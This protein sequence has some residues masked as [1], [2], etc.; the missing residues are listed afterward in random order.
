MQASNIANF[1]GTEGGFAGDGYGNGVGIRLPVNI[2]TA[3]GGFIVQ[4]RPEP[5]GEQ[6]GDGT[7]GTGQR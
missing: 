4:L 6:E 1:H 5:V 7:K 2:D 3:K